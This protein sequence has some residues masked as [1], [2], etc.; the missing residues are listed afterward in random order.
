MSRHSFRKLI[1]LLLAVDDDVSVEAGAAAAG[2]VV[3]EGHLEVVAK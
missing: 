2:H 1:F 3:G